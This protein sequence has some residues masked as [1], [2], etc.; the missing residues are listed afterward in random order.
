[1]KL[2]A[3]QELMSTYSRS[4]DEAYQLTSSNISPEDL[5]LYR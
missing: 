2:S 1:M 5:A 4:Q 3:D